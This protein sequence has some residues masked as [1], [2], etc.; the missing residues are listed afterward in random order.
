MIFDLN[1]LHRPDAQGQ[2]HECVRSP[3][4]NSWRNP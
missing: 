2:G 1:H 4:R 3:L